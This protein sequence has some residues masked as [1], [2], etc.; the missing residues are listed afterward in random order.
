MGNTTLTEWPRGFKLR[1]KS[2][3]NF[4]SG[5]YS[6]GCLRLVFIHMNSCI[7][8][9]SCVMDDSECLKFL[10]QNIFESKVL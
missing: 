9:Q 2:L 1:E 4:D 10:L 6:M 3:Y 7:V 8:L 5:D